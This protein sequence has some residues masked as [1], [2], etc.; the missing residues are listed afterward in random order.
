VTASSFNRRRSPEGKARRRKARRR[1][2]AGTA[3]AVA[4]TG[5]MRLS[6][7]GANVSVEPGRGSF[8]PSSSD[9][10]PGL[11]LPIWHDRTIT[12]S[13]QPARSPTRPP[14]R[15]ATTFFEEPVR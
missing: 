8:S 10:R 1:G 3:D 15:R 14:S 7:L 11:L 2:P 9:L 5:L 13:R 4:G 6:L 12:A